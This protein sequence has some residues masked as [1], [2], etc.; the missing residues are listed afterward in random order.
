MYNRFA[1][2]GLT[3]LR[4]KG[5]PAAQRASIFGSAWGRLAFMEKLVRGRLIV[6]F[7]STFSGFISGATPIIPGVPKVS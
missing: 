3:N 4:H 2:A 1:R 7:R 5:L 6:C